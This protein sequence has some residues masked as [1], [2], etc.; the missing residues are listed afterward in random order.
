MSDY[1]LIE[2]SNCKHIATTYKTYKI[3]LI[4]IMTFISYHFNETNNIEYISA[5]FN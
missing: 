4:V 2:L 5:L 3:S 1:N